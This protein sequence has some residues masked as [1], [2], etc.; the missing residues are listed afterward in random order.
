MNRMLLAGM[1]VLGGAGLARADFEADLLA[2][3][4]KDDRAT[5][6][7]LRREIEGA[8][9]QAGSLRY[10]PERAEKLLR[11]GLDLLNKDKALPAADRAG[12]AGRVEQKLTEIRG[13]IAARKS[14]EDKRKRE[15][16]ATE[17]AKTKT[18]Y[19]G[20]TKFLG[21][22]TEQPEPRERSPIFFSPLVAPFPSSADVTVTPVVSP[23][24]RW[25]RI[26]ISAGFIFP[27]ISYVP[28]PVVTPTVLEGPGKNLTVLPIYGIRYVMAAVPAG[29]TTASISTT[30]MA[31]D[32]GSATVG[33]YSSSILSSVET[34]TPLVSGIPYLSP[35]VSSRA[36]G[37]S[38]SGFGV[39]VSPRVIVL[40]DD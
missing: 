3:Y 13:V 27:R 7:K 37:V 10:D 32:G 39:S 2:Q 38:R 19:V 17:L 29:F 40:G 23:D 34:G 11:A 36:Y 15:W 30:V 1:L 28:V 16:A 26:G 18:P 35:F 14:D 9:A 8:L 21:G 33:G 22:P 12:L 20:G 25:V 4:Q 24:R 6:D 31:P 5:A